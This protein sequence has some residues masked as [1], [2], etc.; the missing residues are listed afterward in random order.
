MPFALAMSEESAGFTIFQGYI[1]WPILL[2]IL[3]LLAS[4]LSTSSMIFLLPIE[5][6]NPVKFFG[7]I[8]STLTSSG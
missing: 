3:V 6:P 8:W 7:V 4:R 1:G 5:P 2:N